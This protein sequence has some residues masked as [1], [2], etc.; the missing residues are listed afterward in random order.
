MMSTHWLHL[1]A[2]VHGYILRVGMGTALSEHY[3]AD[4]LLKETI[5]K[6]PRLLLLV[7][8]L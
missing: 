2:N 7:N 5:M 6:Y 3:L 8:L 1:Q 4:L